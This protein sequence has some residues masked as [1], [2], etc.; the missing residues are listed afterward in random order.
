MIHIPIPA[1]CNYSNRIQD[2]W[3]MHK[4]YLKNKVLLFASNLPK[5]THTIEVELEPRYTGSF[6]LNPARAELMYFPTFYG[7]NGMRKIT[8]R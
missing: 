1:G 4:E 7:R 3:N 5:G 6:M 8:I 2:R